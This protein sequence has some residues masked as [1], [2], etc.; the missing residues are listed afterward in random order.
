MIY[1]LVPLFIIYVWY[2]VLINIIMIMCVLGISLPLDYN[3]RTN[4]I[5]NA[6]SFNQLCHVFHILI[7]MLL[8][9]AFLGNCNIRYNFL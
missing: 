9:I 5:N 6:F 7:Y 2:Q 1:F 8:P 3:N 4:H